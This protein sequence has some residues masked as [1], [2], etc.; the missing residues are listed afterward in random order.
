MT[1]KERIKENKKLCEEM[2]F[3]IPR[4]RWTDKIDD[5][6]DYS[7][8]ELDE[9]G[10]RELEL[11]FFREITPLLKKANYLDKYRIMDSKEKWGEWRLY[12]N[13]LPKEIFEE[14]NN[15]LDKYV[16]LSRHTCIYCGDR[17]AKM[18]YCGWI[19]P[20]CKSCWEKNEY[21]N[22]I[23]YEK[24]TKEDKDDEE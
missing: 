12:E 6:Y 2:P 8:T 15:I 5:D 20:C 16:E 7:Y 14:Y 22:H 4:N 10:W 1:K 3:L 9:E 13:G 17:N 24:A 18:T 21:M 23:P 19:F 11:E